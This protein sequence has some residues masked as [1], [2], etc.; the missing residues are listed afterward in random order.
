[1]DTT[2]WLSISGAWGTH[3]RL[4]LKALNVTPG[5]V[6]E[7]GVGHDSTPYLHEYCAETYR[8]LVSCESDHAWLEKFRHLAA[9]KHVLVA[10][11]EDYSDAPVD[12]CDWGVALVDHAPCHQRH[13][14]AIRLA[15]R[16]QIVVIHDTENEPGYLL[17]RVWPK[18]RFRI[19]DRNNGSAV[20]WTSAVSNLLDVRQLLA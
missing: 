11:K 8:R 9:P 10:V 3:R 19:D 12:A 18:F 20:G 7:L 5:S 4:L 16:A 1:M 14:E 13:I 17:E 6:I 2:K 15:H